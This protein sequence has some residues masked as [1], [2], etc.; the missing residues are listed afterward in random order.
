MVGEAGS[1]LVQVISRAV[2]ATGTAPRSSRPARDRRVRHRSS[3]TPPSR[4]RSSTDSFLR[5]RASDRR[6]QL[7]ALQMNANE[8]MHLPVGVGAGYHSQDR[9]EHHRRQIEPLAFRATMVRIERK[10]SNSDAGMRQPPI[11][12]VAYRFRH[13]CR[14]VLNGRHR[15][16]Q[17]P[18]EGQLQLLSGDDAVPRC[19]VTERA[20]SKSR[21]RWPSGCRPQV[22]VVA[23]RSGFPRHGG[24]VYVDQG[25]PI[26]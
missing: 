18:G 17:P 1:H 21:S 5:D 2:A 24:K 9:V 7:Q 12:V 3:R 14:G 19:C 23:K 15:S 22:Y 10:I 4:S 16:E 8:F 26:F 11:S 13:F 25:R 6:R 20:C